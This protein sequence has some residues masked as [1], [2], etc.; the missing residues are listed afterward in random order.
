MIKVAG[1]IQQMQHAKQLQAVL[2]IHQAV[3]V[4]SKAAGTTIMKK[5]VQAIA[6]GQ[7][8]IIVMKL[9]AMKLATTPLA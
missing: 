7:H 8:I 1:T 9:A 2:G 3:I 4:M 5:I 6:L